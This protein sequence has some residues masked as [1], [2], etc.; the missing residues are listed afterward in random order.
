[1]LC[2][3]PYCA[4]W[5][6]A[7]IWALFTEHCW[8]RFNS[9]FGK[10]W[11]YFLTRAS[12]F[13]IGIVLVCICILFLFWIYSLGSVWLSFTSAIKCLEWLLCVEWNVKLCSFV[14][15]CGL[16]TTQPIISQND[17]FISV[18]F[19]WLPLLV[20]G[21]SCRSLLLVTSSSQFSVV[22]WVGVRM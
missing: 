17:P 8:F 14:V 16:C 4:Q 9:N 20:L 2:C 12:L 1:M 15:Q 7:H 11:I 10:F 13:V 19:V 22:S 5:Y 6:H 3:I 21:L 18:Q